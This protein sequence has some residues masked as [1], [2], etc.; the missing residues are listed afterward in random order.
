M[1]IATSQTVAI[2]FEID[3]EA[4]NRKKAKVSS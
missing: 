3:N 2:P 4:N 1:I